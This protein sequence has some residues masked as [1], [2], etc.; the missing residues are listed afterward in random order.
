MYSY[1]FLIKKQIQVFFRCIF[2]TKRKDWTM[3]K[4]YV[5]LDH[6]VCTAIV[7]SLPREELEEKYCILCE[8]STMQE[9]RI[10]AYLM[11]LLGDEFYNRY[12]YDECIG[13]EL[14]VCG[15]FIEAGLRQGEVWE[16]ERR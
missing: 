11:E 16:E 9:A 7:S 4:Y 3:D 1:L 10:A 5:Y 13:Q 6:D 2:L 15:N 8:L 12:R 14:R